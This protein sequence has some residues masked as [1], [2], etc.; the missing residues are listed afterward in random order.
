MSKTMKDQEQNQKIANYWSSINESKNFSKAV[1]WLANPIIHKLYQ[2]RAV[3]GRS[4]SH[5]LDFC[6]EHFVRKNNPVDRILSVGCGS[7]NLERHLAKLNAFKELDAIDIAPISIEI[8]K[9]KA[10]EENIKGINYECRNVEESNFPGKDYDAVFYNM[11]LHHMFHIDKILEQTREVMKPDAFLFVN[12][13]VGPNRFDFTDREKEVISAIHTLI[14][15]KF[16]ISLAQANYGSIQKEICLP[17]PDEVA[18]VDPSESV[19]SAQIMST[20]P[21]YFDI[22]EFNPIG[23]TILQ[24]LLQN[25]AGHFRE[26]DRDSI[27]VLDLLIKAEDT[28]IKVN[29]LKP[30]FA[31]IVAKPK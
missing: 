12:E 26:E 13:Y 21:K 17:H 10:E 8:A 4:Y 9:Q 18:R 23:G 1:Y 24:F 29:D 16:R 7:G 25:I 27:A 15:E 14:P 2:H 20:I 28:L 5:W 6:I 31:L 11:S 30:H 22:I 19:C 3:G